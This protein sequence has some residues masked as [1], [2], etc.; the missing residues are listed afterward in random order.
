M[1]EFEPFLQVRDADFSV[2]RGS[3]ACLV[4]ECRRACLF[5]LQRMKSM[6]RP[7]EAYFK[8]KQN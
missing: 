2:S 3:E 6:E 1:K 5:L 8:T 4:T 7:L